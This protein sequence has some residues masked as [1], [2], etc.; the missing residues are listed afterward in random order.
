MK[1]SLIVF[2]AFIAL[3]NLQAQQNMGIGTTPDASA[4]LDIY[5]TDKGVL[6]PRLTETQKNAITTPATGLLVFQTDNTPGFYYFDGSTW[7]TIAPL[8]TTGGVSTPSWELTGNTFAPS[9]A[10]KLG[11]LSNTPLKLYVN[12]AVAGILE[13]DAA[14]NAKNTLLGYQSGITTTGTDNVGLGYKTLNL[15]ST[16][17]DNV[18]VGSEAGSNASGSYNVFLGKKAGKYATGNNNVFVGN[19]AGKNETNSN[20]L[21]ISNSATTTPLVYGDFSSKTLKFNADS[22]F[23]GN[24]KNPNQAGQQK[25]RLI[26]KD[27]IICE[28]LKIALSNSAQWADYVF[29]PTYNLLPLNQVE[30]FILKN[31]HLPNVPSAQDLAN[32]GIDVTAMQAKQMEK[33]EELTL[34][35]IEMNKQIELLKKENKKLNEKL[36]KVTK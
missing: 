11:T 35:V 2:V 3:N 34:Y 29:A 18:A 4:V 14:G 24:V 32:T 16:G 22:L 1:K 26:V 12:G 30:K 36:N 27:G 10:P 20:K 6:I 19:E 21:Y 8:A 25:Y 5:S 7:K 28:H 17:I 9:D 33:I 13:S 31:K 15:N 23:L